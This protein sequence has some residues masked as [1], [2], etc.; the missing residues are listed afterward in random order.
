MVD[1]RPGVQ[2]TAHHRYASVREPMFREGPE[3]GA[4]GGPVGP[5]GPVGPIWVGAWASWEGSARDQRPASTPRPVRGLSEHRLANTGVSVVSRI[6]G[7]RT[8]VDHAAPRPSKRWAVHT[9]SE[10]PT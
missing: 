5:V 6:L 8:V 9:A 2:Y 1:D 7:S 4:D 3:P 10:V